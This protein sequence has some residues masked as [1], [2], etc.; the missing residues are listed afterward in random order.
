MLEDES[1]SESDTST[2]EAAVA[3]DVCVVDLT[4]GAV[5]AVV[6]ELCLECLRERRESAVRRMW[7]L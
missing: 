7:L 1:P 5:T 4:S 6:P 2:S 3:V